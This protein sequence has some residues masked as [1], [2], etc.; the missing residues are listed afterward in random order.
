MKIQSLCLAVLA[1]LLAGASFTPAQDP[2][3]PQEPGV[4]FLVRH[5]EKGGEGRDPELSEAG[6]ARAAELVE[7][8]RDSRIQHVHSTDYL[9]TQKTAGPVAAALGLE[10]TS[11]DPRDP[12]SVLETLRAGGRHLVVGHS[13]TTPAMV[14]LLGGDPGEPLGEDDYDRLYIVTLAPDGPVST[15]LLHYGE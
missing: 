15:V 7:M 2:L 6:E 5:A 11:Y 4:V 1:L 3:P 13:N 9:R 10:V 12:S 8:L 14:K